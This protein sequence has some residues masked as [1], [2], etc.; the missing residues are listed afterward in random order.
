M[1]KVI[2]LKEFRTNTDIWI[3][4][5]KHGHDLIVLRR[6]QPI[7]KI[8]PMDDGEWEEVID[9]TKIKK[10]GVDIKKILSNFDTRIKNL[11]KK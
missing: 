2:G 7:F 3:K 9:F 1:K 6:S 4:H 11:E 10:G 8:V 5:V